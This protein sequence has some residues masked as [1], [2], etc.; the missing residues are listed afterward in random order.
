MFKPSLFRCI[1]F[2]ICVLSCNTLCAAHS[3]NGPKITNQDIVIKGAVM[4]YDTNTHLTVAEGNTVKPAKATWG[5]NESTKTITASKIRAQ[6]YDSASDA[7][8]NKHHSDGLTPDIDWIEATDNVVITVENT[9]SENAAQTARTKQIMTADLC[10][11]KGSLI[12]CR[13]HVSITAADNTVTGDTA[14]F[15]INKDTFEIGASI[16]HQTTARIHPQ[17]FKQ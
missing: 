10:R 14:T 4:R 6:L 7:P 13:G 8:K 11:S 16:G 17:S 15:D 12:T 1:C 9:E 3:T 5:T 2:L